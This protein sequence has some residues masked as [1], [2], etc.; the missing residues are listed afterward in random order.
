M[1]KTLLLLIP[2]CCSLSVITGCQ[3][4]NSGVDVIIEGGGP[5]P[6]S[7][8]GTWKDEKYGWEFVFRPDGTISSAVIASGGVRLYPGKDNS[9]IRHQGWHEA[10]Y[11]LGTWVVQY[12]PQQHEL[13]VEVVVENYYVKV[14]EQG[15]GLTGH[16]TDWFVG[17]VSQD[18]Q[19]W[20]AEWFTFPKHTLL[21][22][23][24]TDFPFDPNDNPIAV[25]VF[26]KQ[27]KTN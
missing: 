23:E 16:S 2:L 25:V 3:T 22:P 27:Q 20:Q 5:F 12:S 18:A 7:L 10:S 1:A 21:V 15:R 4:P 6:K 24:P 17:R 9:A 19:N 8:A 26:G 11:E 13:V 14:D